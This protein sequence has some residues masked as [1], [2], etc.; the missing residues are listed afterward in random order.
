[1][2]AAIAILVLALVMVLA[3]PKPHI[4]NARA[5]KLGDFQFPR[6]KE[7]DPVQ[8]LIGRVRARSPVS[9]WFGDYHPDPI[10][11]KQKTGLFSSKKVVTGYKY[12]V[13]IDLCWGTGPNVRLRKL[14][15]GKYLIWEGNLT[16]NTTIAID[17][18][19][20]FGG[21]DERGGLRGMIDFYPG[22][23]SEEPNTYLQAKAHADVP[24]YV[25]QCRTVFR[26][27]TFVSHTSVPISW[28]GGNVDFLIDNSSSSFYWGN[29]TQIEAINAELQ[30]MTTYLH[31]TYSILPSGD[32]VTPF[33]CMMAACVERNMLSISVDDID[34]PSWVAATQTCYNEGL[35][36]SFMIQST[37]TG[38]DIA[39]ECLRIADGIL[40]Q[41]PTTGKIV[42][43]LIRNDYVI[44][45]LPVLDQSIVKDLTSFDKTTWEGTYN[46]ARVKFKDRNDE[47]ADKMAS[48]QDFANIN[49]QQKVRSTEITIP[50]C[51]VN[52]MA[53]KLAVR[54][55]SFLSVPLFSIE[56]RCNRKASTL[57]PGDCFVFEWAPY[58]IKNMV[59]RV[60]Q[61]D[62]GTLGDGTV[63]IN[64]VQDVYA[65]NV[66]VF[67][68]P[69]GTS[70]QNPITAPIDLYNPGLFELPYEMSATPAALVA[71]MG[72]RAK[73]TDTGYH[74]YSGTT[75]GDSNLTFVIEERSGTPT[76]TLSADLPVGNWGLDTTNDVMLTAIRQS[77]DIP[78]LNN[79]DELY[80]GHSIV[81]IRST[82]GDELIAYQSFDGTK[83]HGIIRGI[84]GTT[85]KLHLTGATAYFLSEGFGLENEDN[86][87]VTFP[88]TRYAKLPSFNGLGEQDLVDATEVSLTVIGKAIRAPVPGK[89]YAQG[90]QLAN[91][92]SVSGAWSLTWAHRNRLDPQVR[93]LNEPSVQP[94][95]GTHYSIEIARADTGAVLASVADVDA[96]AAT[97]SCIYVGDI[98]IRLWSR[99]N[100]VDS[101]E[102]WE[103]VVACAGNSASGATNQILPDLATYTL[104]GG[105]A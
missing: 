51:F 83:L 30:R 79:D 94:E 85:P 74:I 52:D 5:A 40:Y 59:M 82:A 102:K 88:Q 7:G 86:P 46:Q 95:T 72:S 105:H 19:T 15:A 103:F 28:L 13:G 87:Y 57:K 20:L 101:Y 21:P 14:W 16:T 78:A 32:D 65:A 49:F 47:Y 44:A 12:H 81:L 66:A 71:T 11:K 77:G 62:L 24:A 84:Y 80:S 39:E 10:V 90:V 92:A 67:A 48:A 38:K 4:E 23:W 73:T 18:P 17:K 26:G 91:G 96:T 54:Q 64:A 50:G 2:W 8:W 3:A 9:L 27:G 93:R 34:L 63:T 70:W 43:K 76:A 69:G 56:I 55:L 89:V 37:V 42:A 97:I 22:N 31:P 33:E 104:D 25:G 53:N 99:L 45:D 60:Q 100:G 98:K 68:P 41:D 6:S 1:M 29:S 58:G 61:V 75:S 36:M 35:G